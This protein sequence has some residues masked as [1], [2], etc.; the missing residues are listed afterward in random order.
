MAYLVYS[1][2]SV[3]AIIVYII[4]VATCHILKEI[5]TAI[6]MRAKVVKTRLLTV[7]VVQIKDAV[8]SVYVKL[9]VA[10][11]FVKPVSK[12]CVKQIVIGVERVLAKVVK[13]VLLVL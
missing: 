12:E 1:Q 8:L 3:K 2:M 4:F 11:A 7:L 6:A 10:M 5:I 13:A 9:T